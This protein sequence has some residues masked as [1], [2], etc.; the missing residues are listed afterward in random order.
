MSQL[1]QLI[2]VMAG[3]GLVTSLAT[4]FVNRR[5]TTAETTELITNA[6]KQIIDAQAVQIDR[7]LAK[8]EALEAEVKQLRTRLKQLEKS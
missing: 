3:T 5:K 8:V 2:L 7:L 6:A 1:W 4:S